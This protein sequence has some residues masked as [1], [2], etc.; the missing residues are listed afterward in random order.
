[1]RLPGGGGGGTGYVDPFAGQ[2]GGGDF[3]TESQVDAA[4]LA[5]AKALAAAKR[6]G[7]A[8]YASGPGRPPRVWGRA[9]SRAGADSAVLRASGG[10]WRG[11][12]TC[13]AWALGFIRV[14]LGL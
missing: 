6:A 9:A 7:P 14:V 5:Q 12:V 8:A 13:A 4:L 10:F 1:M 11:G 2:G 3:Q